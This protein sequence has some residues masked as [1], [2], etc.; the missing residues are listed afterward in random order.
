MLAAAAEGGGVPGSEWPALTALLALCS[1]AP[2]AVC[3]Q[4]T[5]CGAVR[6]LL[7]AAAAA[8]EVPTVRAQRR[9]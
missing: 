4:L 5:H 7:A 9:P 2:A 1:H 8:A 6:P 3:A